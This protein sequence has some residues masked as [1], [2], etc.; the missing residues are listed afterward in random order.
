MSYKKNFKNK[1]SLFILVFAILSLS[2]VP[3]LAKGNNAVTIHLRREGGE[4]LAGRSLKVWKVS[5]DVLLDDVTT[6]LQ[7]FEKI[8]GDELDKSYRSFD[9]EPS[10]KDGAIELSDLA[11]GTYYVRDV[12]AGEGGY[13]VSPFFI[14]LPLDEGKEKDIYPKLIGG[15]PELTLVKVSEDDKRLPGAVFELYKKSS[16]GKDERVSLDKAYDYDPNGSTDVRLTT[17]A[18]GEVRIGKLPA[19]EYIFREIEA[20]K[21]YEI[22]R[23]DTAFT[24]GA[25]ETKV[26]RI[27]NQKRS[28]GKGGYD[29]LKIDKITEKPLRGAS[30]RVTRKV[31]KM[32]R[33]VQ[34]NGKDYVVTSDKKGAFSVSGLDYGTYYLWEIKAPKGYDLLNGSVEFTV[35]ADSKNHRISISNVKSTSSGSGGNT[36]STSD[37]GGGSKRGGKA[38][39]RK[40][41]DIPKTGDVTLIMLTVAGV[42]LACVGV[43]LVKNDSRP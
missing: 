38:R 24:L 41:G 8:N 32:Y 39:S 23:K 29:F 15:V 17:D 43:S 1:I 2:I 9:T 36:T 19:G 25:E 6:R 26:V 31:G 37:G 10:D 40:R 11:D 5:D 14:A 28:D 30:F 42:I 33:T 12:S 20:P 18:N 7:E 34:R 4:A 22:V 3:V 16:D 21:G 27:V 13:R 35:G